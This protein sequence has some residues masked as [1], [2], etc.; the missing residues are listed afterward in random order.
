MDRVAGGERATERHAAILNL[1]FLF[2]DALEQFERLGWR[3]LS[4]QEGYYFRWGKWRRANWNF[5]LM[6]RTLDEYFSEIIPDNAS[7]YDYTE[8]YSCFDRTCKARRLMTTKNGYL[9]WAPDNI[10]GSDEDQARVG[11]KIAIILG[12]S[13][14]IV[15]RPQGNH[16]LVLGE[17]YVQGLMDGEALEFLKSGQCEVQDFLFC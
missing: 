2:T 4:S 13:T 5:R 7:E 9:G 6:G 3:W 15:I 14:P 16:F 10:Y 8:V 17:A 12:C 1:P 11:D